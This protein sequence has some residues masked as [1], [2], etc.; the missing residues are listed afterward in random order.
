MKVVLVMAVTLDGKIG[1]NAGDPVDWTGGADKKKFV[2]ITRRA[3]VMI[4]G[5]RTFDAIGRVL[6]GRKSI[7][8][9]R[10]RQRQSQD[11]NLIFTDA[12][13]EQ[14]L[15]DLEGKGYTEV[16]LIGGGMINGLFASLNLIDEIQLT[17]VPK[18]FGQGLSLFAETLDLDLDLVEMREL[19]PGT[20]LLTYAVNR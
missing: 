10:N 13:P 5:S 15:K 9:T 6:P 12:Q 2:E 1:R 11:E 3:G 17:V 16:A 19:E 8:L 7:V 20:L 14:I 18:I 4:M